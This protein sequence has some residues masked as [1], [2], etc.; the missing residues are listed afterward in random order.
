MYNN[1][2]SCG[3][4]STYRQPWKGEDSTAQLAAKYK[5]LAGLERT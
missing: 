5:P 3:L 1:S 2:S 4:T